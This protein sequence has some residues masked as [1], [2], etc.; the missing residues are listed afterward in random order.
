MQQ[1]MKQWKI[2]DKFYQGLRSTG[3]QPA[4]LYGLAKVHKKMHLSDL[5][6]RYLVA[7]TKT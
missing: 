6:F 3:P 1:L 5:F 4:R 2:N 7:A